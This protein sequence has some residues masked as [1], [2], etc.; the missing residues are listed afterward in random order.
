VFDMKAGIVQMLAAVRLMP[1][2]TAITVLL[3]CDEETGPN[4]LTYSSTNGGVSW[5][6]K[7]TTSTPAGAQTGSDSFGSALSLSDAGTTLLVGAPYT[8]YINSV[9]VG[10]A[11]YAYTYTYASGSWGTPTALTRTA[12]GSRQLGD[13]VSLSP[14]GLSAI[15]G[16]PYGD[17]T[18]AARGGAA[19]Q[20]T[21]PSSWV[22]NQA[23][24][25]TGSGTTDAFGCEVAL[26][27]GAGQPLIGA[28][29]HT[30]AGFVKAGAAYTY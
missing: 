7:S 3:T 28:S 5:A 8:S 21:K 29:G 1:D 12:T 17:S 18:G 23:Y 26:D 14:D 24:T 22:F 9:R 4:V 30:T 15:L 6:Y 27:A 13:A 2:P 11:A 10:G 20:W 19:F 16:M 25:A